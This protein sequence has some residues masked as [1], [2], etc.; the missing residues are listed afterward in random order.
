M[1]L[2]NKN[3][4]GFVGPAC[5]VTLLALITV[6]MICPLADSTYALGDFTNGT[7]C[8]YGA[9]CNST[10]TVD[11]KVEGVAAEKEAF[12]KDPANS[13]QDSDESNLGF[14]VVPNNKV[15]ATEKT[16]EG[17]LGWTVVKKDEIEAT[18]SNTVSANLE[19]TVNGYIELTKIGDD[20][21]VNVDIQPTITE[22]GFSTASTSF[23]VAGNNQDGFGIYVY[24]KED[25]KLSLSSALEDNAMTI[26]PISTASTQAGFGENTWGYTV[27]EADE[28]VTDATTFHGLTTQA[29]A[30]TPVYTYGQPTAGVALKLICGAKVNA[31]LPADTYSTQVV[32]S[33]VAPFNASLIQQNN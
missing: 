3:R 17:N 29:A 9:G 16:E 27:T 31:A 15:D 19:Y 18:T 6:G 13:G 23:Q 33:A 1:R 25:D 30:E 10:T 32:I 7:N 21:D 26:D 5:C 4:V 24:A 11:Q 20:L 28:N 2:K 12:M 8:A 22:G 14:E